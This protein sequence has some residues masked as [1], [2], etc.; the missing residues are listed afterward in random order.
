[1]LTVLPTVPRQ[2]QASV[3]FGV[4]HR[5]GT[6][7]RPG[8]ARLDAA[9][10]TGP[11]GGSAHALT[12]LGA[13]IG[14]APA[15]ANLLFVSAIT[16]T[17]ENAL[18]AGGDGIASAGAHLVILVEVFSQSGVFLYDVPGPAT[19]VYEGGETVF[20][21]DARGGTNTHSV[22][23]L[24]PVVGGNKYWVWLESIQHVS[25]GGSLAAA[26]SNFTYDFGPLFFNYL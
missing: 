8:R 13:S 1:M 6:S 16:T 19:T 9:L 3:P 21:F 10:S 15:G 26:V 14:A 24:V 5:Q 25:S 2:F 22:S 7:I 4:V 18:L 11:P 20:G 23:I 12:G 17:F